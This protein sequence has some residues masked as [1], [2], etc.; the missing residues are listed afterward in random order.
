MVQE[1]W[2]SYVQ[3]PLRYFSALY[4]YEGKADL[5]RGNWNP[6]KLGVTMYV[7]EIIK[8]HFGKKFHITLFV[9]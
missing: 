4:N 3:Y 7:S 8:H 9:F 2:V 1:P 6:K 5:S